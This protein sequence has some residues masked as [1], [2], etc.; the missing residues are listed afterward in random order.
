VSTN[1]I[2]VIQH[3]CENKKQKCKMN[4][5]ND[6]N[7]GQNKWPKKKSDKHK[8]K[9]WNDMSLSQQRVGKT[10]R[11]KIWVTRNIKVGWKMN[12]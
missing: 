6:M 4:S 11:A 8:M 9:K 5:W 3:E 12:T 1:K 7:I 2:N 10:K